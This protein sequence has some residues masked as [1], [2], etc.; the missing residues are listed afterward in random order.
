[1]VV[2]LAELMLLGFISLLLAVFQN[3]IAEICI[4]KE[5]ASKWL[6]CKKDDEA[7]TKTSA[8]FQS[9]FTHFRL[10]AESSDS[11]ASCHE[12]SFFNFSL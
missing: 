7:E 3:R 12:V 6:P 4:T 8:H 2:A 5:L 1:M 11:T 10:L 9:S